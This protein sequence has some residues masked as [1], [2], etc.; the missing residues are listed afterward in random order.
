MAGQIWSEDT[1]GRFFYSDELS[2]YLR[3]ELT[4]TCKFRQFLDAG[5]GDQ[6][7]LHR[8][9]DFTWNTFTRIKERGDELAEDEPIPESGFSVSQNSLKITEYGHSVPYTGKLDD[10]SKQSVL[11]VIDQALRRDCQ[12]VF[13]I[14]VW[15]KFNATNLRVMPAGNGASATGVEFATNGD[16][17]VTSTNNT[18][19]TLKHVARIATWMKTRNI[20][21][22]EGSSYVCLTRA[23]VLDP[24]LDELEEIFKHTT[25]GLRHIY[26]GEVATYRNMRFVEQTFIPLG[27]AKD[28]TT[29][30]PRTE[31][32]DPWNNAKSSWAFFLG[33]DTGTEAMVIP[34]EIRAQIPNDFGRSRAVAWY[35]MTGFGITRTGDNAT[36]V[37][38]DSA[39]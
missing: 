13:D 33:A 7:G 30:N 29:F 27:G 25:M 20:P 28:S 4:P 15:R 17:G 8:G 11:D 37:K 24:L 18:N 38:W 10:L 14:A 12:E 9:E 34:E 31:T 5:D 3:E 16:D 23:E 22:F 26:E 39:A 36:I 1:E 35:A 2:E 6:K 19:M 32:P 21:A